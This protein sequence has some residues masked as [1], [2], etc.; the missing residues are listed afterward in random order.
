MNF[1]DTIDL[2]QK[3]MN[4]AVLRQNTIANNIA[5]ADTP[6]FKRSD[7]NFESSLKAAFDAASRKPALELATSEP[8]HISNVP[9]V[10][11][12]DVQPRRVLDYTSTTQA[13]GNNVDAE[14][15][16]QLM[17]QNQMM[18][19]LLANSVSFQFNQVNMALQSA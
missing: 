15:E 14:H 6:N 19:E 18:Y 9:T 11:W 16:A 5:N 10:N 7:I 4:V 12:K 17:L 2:L 3:S 13:N 8:G 1:G